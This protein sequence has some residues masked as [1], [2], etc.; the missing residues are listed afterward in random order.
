M[1]GYF[2]YIPSYPGTAFTNYGRS[3]DIPGGELTTNPN[4]N[5]LLNTVN[6][7]SGDL[8]TNWQTSNGALPLYPGDPAVTTG[9]YPYAG[10]PPFLTGPGNT[11]IG[12]PDIFGSGNGNGDNNPLPN[13]GPGPVIPNDG[14]MWN[15]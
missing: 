8:F 11:I 6:G 1:S 2:P 3:Q 13:M 14:N 10:L 12:G 5:Y 4:T 9:G 15:C 7:I